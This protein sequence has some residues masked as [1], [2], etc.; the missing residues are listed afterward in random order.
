MTSRKHA[1]LALIG[2][3]RCTRTLLDTDYSLVHITSPL[4]YQHAIVLRIEGVSINHITAIILAYLQAAQ[5]VALTLGENPD[6]D[7]FTSGI[8]GA[9]MEGVK[10]LNS[11]AKIWLGSTAHATYAGQ[12]G[13][14]VH[15]IYPDDDKLLPQTQ[16]SL[17]EKGRHI[18]TQYCNDLTQSI[19]KR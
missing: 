12:S 8:V 10:H 9:L 19:A 2:G 15:D 1:L 18:T 4:A 7:E 16:L 6:E 3:I 13:V 5:G 17:F 11:D 14:T